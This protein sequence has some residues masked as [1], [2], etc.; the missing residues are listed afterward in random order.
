VVGGD[1][2]SPT[3]FT[4]I[5]EST[6]SYYMA[7]GMS[8]DEFWYQDPMIAKYYREADVVKRKKRNEE[9]WVQGMYFANAISATLSKKGKYPEKPFDIFPKTAMEKQAEAETERKKIIEHFTLLKQRWERTHGN[10][11]QSHT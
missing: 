9:M 8:Y 2:K 11:R 6:C 10:D 5:F 4:E 3:S 7:L 1:V